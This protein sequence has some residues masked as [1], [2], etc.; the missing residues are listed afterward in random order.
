MH[1]LK[2]EFFCPLLDFQILIFKTVKRTYNARKVAR[3]SLLSISSVRIPYDCQ[4]IPV[5]EKLFSKLNLK[6]FETSEK[7]NKVFFG[8][9]TFRMFDCL[10]WGN[11]KFSC[12]NI[13][14]GLCIN[15]KI[16]IQWNFVKP[17]EIH[18]V[19]IH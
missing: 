2:F 12:A 14:P 3:F 9:N 6:L 19:L 1:L 15:L 17:I 10:F 16:Q 13:G 4:K 18:F 11:C 5:L 7:K 8:E